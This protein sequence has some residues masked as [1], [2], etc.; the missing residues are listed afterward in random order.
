MSATRI[1]PVLRASIAERARHRCSYCQTA[2]SVTG[3]MFTVD[4]V[5]PEALGG[6]TT[7]ENLCLAC[8][9]C[10]RLKRARIA[11]VDPDSGAVVRLFNPNVQRLA[12]TLRM[13]E[14]WPANRRLDSDRTSHGHSASTQPR[15]IGQCPTVVDTGQLA[16]ACG[17]VV[18][19]IAQCPRRFRSDRMPS[20]KPSSHRVPRPAA[21]Q[22]SLTSPLAPPVQASARRRPRLPHA[23][24]R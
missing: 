17:L 5:I 14:G 15:C 20:L 10:N 13:A 22:R 8:W 12:R 23:Q 7:A 18:H 19:V 3:S 16:S 11:G 24:R 2:E 1:P 21:V 6:H 9:E 4:H